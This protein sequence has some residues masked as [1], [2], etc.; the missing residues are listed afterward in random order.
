MEQQL[1]IRLPTTLAQQLE[2]TAKQMRRKRSDV[3][4]LALEQYFTIATS[5]RPFD[6]VSDLVGRIESG[7]PDLG[8]NHRAHLIKR[9]RHGR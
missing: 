4:R 2:Q 6:R 7:V 1:S 3:V 5:E 8:Q 9:I